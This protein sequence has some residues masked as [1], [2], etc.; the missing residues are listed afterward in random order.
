MWQVLNVDVALSLLNETHEQERKQQKAVHT[1]PTGFPG[2]PASLVRGRGC[3]S[4]GR[5]R[6]FVLARSC[7]VVPQVPA[8][9]SVGLCGSVLAQPRLFVPLTSPGHAATSEQVLGAL[10]PVPGHPERKEGKNNS[11]D[12]PGVPR[13]LESPAVQSC[14]VWTLDSRGF[15]QRRSGAHDRCSAARHVV[16]HRVQGKPRGGWARRSQEG[17]IPPLPVPL[18]RLCLLAARI[19]GWVDTHSAAQE[20][21]SCPGCPGLPG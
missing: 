18:L 19:R 11:R 21:R 8:G 4:R 17:Q 16:L 1:W 13:Q 10:N 3:G 14:Q 5:G 20:S 15:A 9:R 7:P 12:H 6:S 2:P